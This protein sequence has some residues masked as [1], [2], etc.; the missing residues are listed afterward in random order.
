MKPS[1][2]SSRESTGRQ[3]VFSSLCVQYFLI[4]RESMH[5][6]LGI[7]QFTYKKRGVEGDMETNGINQKFKYEYKRGIEKKYEE[8]GTRDT[9]GKKDL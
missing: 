4:C 2:H 8:V 9:V 1:G 6:N 7:N 5:Y 3:S